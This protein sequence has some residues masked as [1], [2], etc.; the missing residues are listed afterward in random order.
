VPWKYLNFFLADDMRLAEIGREYRAGRMLTGEVKKELI[1]VRAAPAGPRAA[2]CAR[3]PAPPCVAR[4]ARMRAGLAPDAR[5]PHMGL[6]P[7]RHGPLRGKHTTWCAQELVSKRAGAAAAA[8]PRRRRA[9]PR[10]VRWGARGRRGAQVLQA[11]VA[12]H[13]A[14]RARVTDEVLRQFTDVRPMP[15]LFAAA[16]ERAA[17]LAADGPQAEK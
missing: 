4:Q 15:D 8:H 6:A 12:E 9:R 7:A 10:R 3:C 11:L 13:Q 16:R 2:P 1:G 5:K 17:A 14:A